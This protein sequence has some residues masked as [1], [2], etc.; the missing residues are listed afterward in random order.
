M[1]ILALEKEVTNCNAEKY[2]LFLKEEAE[3]VWELM[4][5]NII[6]EIYFTKD[7]NNA[8]L[9]LECNDEI[10]AGRILKT[11]PLVREGIITFEINALLPYNGFKRLFI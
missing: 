9:M 3:K 7:G 4:Q 6:R 11:L 8:V 2:K 1:K 10:E 5:E